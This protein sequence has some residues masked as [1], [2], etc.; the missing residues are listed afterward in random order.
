MY[1]KQAPR[2]NKATKAKNYPREPALVPV[3]S[4]NEHGNVVISAKVKAQK[5]ANRHMEQ[6][7]L[8][9]NGKYWDKT[10]PELQQITVV[11]AEL[12]IKINGE[13]A[14]VVFQ[15]DAIVCEHGTINFRN[16]YTNFGGRPQVYCTI[17]PKQNIGFGEL[18]SD[19][20]LILFYHN[21][22][23]RFMIIFNHDGK[24][25]YIRESFKSFNENIIKPTVMPKRKTVKPAIKHESSSSDDSDVPKKKGRYF[26]ESDNQFKLLADE[27]NYVELLQKYGKLSDQDVSFYLKGMEKHFLISVNGIA[28]LVTFT[29]DEL[30]IRYLSDGQ[31]VTAAYTTGAT[32]GKKTYT[33]FDM[34]KIVLD[35]KSNK[36]RKHI[37][38]ILGFITSTVIPNL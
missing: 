18:E 1:P 24:G 10:N 22:A 17:M 31:L 37:I 36:D 26:A 2:F 28:Y 30:I 32:I 38:R 20:V 25:G 14:K 11:G 4:V 3:A 29:H 23:T 16:E 33:H 15:R 5:Y 13:D 21:D 27:A 6:E 12:L 7:I 34:E 35:V 8:A 19:V 9:A